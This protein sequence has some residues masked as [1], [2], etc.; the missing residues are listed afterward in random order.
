VAPAAQ[1]YPARIECRRNRPQ[2]ST[3]EGR[4]SL[5][6]PA[7]IDNANGDLDAIAT[8]RRLED[9]LE[10]RPRAPRTSRQQP[11]FAR[12][13]TRS[14]FGRS[15]VDAEQQPAW[16]EAPGVEEPSVQDFDEAL[17]SGR[18]RS[19]NF[20]V[21]ANWRWNDMFRTDAGLDNM[22][23]DPPDFMAAITDQR[24]GILPNLHAAARSS[25]DDDLMKRAEAMRALGCLEEA[26][27]VHLLIASS[28]LRT[29]SV[30]L[31][32][33]ATHRISAVRRII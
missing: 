14:T 8:R 27:E 29:F 5:A 30:R 19:L 6:C 33:L 21:L 12:E 16:R 25:S 28:A 3:I 4:S 10:P 24:R 17:A 9:L 11:S 22:T 1:F 26:R 2:S 20:A 23:P 15:Y 32:A 31:A 13:L 7:P 18:H